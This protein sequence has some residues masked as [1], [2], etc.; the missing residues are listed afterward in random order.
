MLASLRG[1]LIGEA[2]EVGKRNDTNEGPTMGGYPPYHQ[3]T[4]AQKEQ[5]GN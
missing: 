1:N 4:L 3:L 2:E 5:T